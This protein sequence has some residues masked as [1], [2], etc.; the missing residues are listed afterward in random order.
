[1]S[2]RTNSA[3]AAAKS[4]STSSSERPAF[5]SPIALA[6]L[7]PPRLWGL[8][9]HPIADFRNGLS[10]TSPIPSPTERSSAPGIRAGGCSDFTGVISATGR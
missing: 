7:L 9:V 1:M 2:S 10:S 6:P 3:A 5:M 4:I 8:F